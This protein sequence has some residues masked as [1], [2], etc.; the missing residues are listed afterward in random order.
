M[1]IDMNVVRKNAQAAAQ[2]GA[3]VLD[4]TSKG[5]FNDGKT[6][7]P[8]GHATFAKAYRLMKEKG[9]NPVGY[10]KSPAIDG[11]YYGFYSAYGPLVE[12]LRT[13]EGTN[14]GDILPEGKDTEATAMLAEAWNRIRA[15][16]IYLRELRER[17]KNG[18]T[19]GTM[20]RAGSSAAEKRT[21]SRR[22]RTLT[23]RTGAT[24]TTKKETSARGLKSRRNLANAVAESFASSEGAGTDRL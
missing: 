2:R 13:T 8:K 24:M 21:D 20:L 6:G 15:R 4:V 16:R 11:G 7:I 10:G 17:R 9:L 23:V 12:G 22:S 3:Q 18:Q 1:N 19:P 14:P 5:W